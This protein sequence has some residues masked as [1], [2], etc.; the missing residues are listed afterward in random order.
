MKIRPALVVV[1]DDHLLVM[2]YSYAGGVRWNLPGGNLEFGESVIP[3]LI[4]EW[5]EELAVEVEVGK[6]LVV[7]ETDRDGQRTL[8]MVFEG[9]ILQGEPTLQP[10]ET[11][12]EALE[13]IPIANV[14]NLALYPAVQYWL[15]T[16]WEGENPSSYAGL[17][18]Q[19]WL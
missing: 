13:W 19:V 6:L 7:G 14:Q 16:Y 9:H 8:H 12:A 3:A 10:L 15:Q 1:Q 4:R 18:P 11:T 17:L 5:K 2:R